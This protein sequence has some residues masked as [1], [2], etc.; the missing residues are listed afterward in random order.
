MPYPLSKRSRISRVQALRPAG[1]PAREL[2][3][4]LTDRRTALRVLLCALSI[5]A[6]AASL[7]AWKF[8]FPYRLGQ[9]PEHGVAARLDFERIN[10]VATERAR[11]LKAAQV[12]Y[13]FRQDPAPLQKLPSQFKASLHQLLDAKSVDALPVETRAALGLVAIK[14]AADKPPAVQPAERF[15]QLK[16]AVGD[17]PQ[18]NAIE[19]ELRAFLEPIDR[20]GVMPSQP[21]PTI[22][23]RPDDTLQ[24][25]SGSHQELMMMS[26]LQLPQLLSPAG[27]LGEAW[28]RFPTLSK[29]RPTVEHW[30]AAKVPE[31]LRYDAE[32]TQA[33]RERARRSVGVVKEVYKKGNLLVLPG[34]RIDAEHLALLTAEYNASDPADFWPLRVLTSVALILVLT[35]L[36]GYYVVRQEPKL[37]GSAKRLSIYLT[38]VVLTAALARSLSFDPWRAEVIPLTALVMILAIAYNQVLATL[39]GFSLSLI[40]TLATGADL[41]HFVVL[42]SAAAA[43]VIPL[44]RVSSR[45]TLIHVGLWSGLTY[46]FVSWGTAAIESSSFGAL[47]RDQ[48]VL[49]EALRGAGWCL[50]SGFLVAGSL[51]FIE[52]A[53]GVVTNISLLEMGDISHPLLQEL[54]RRA[55]GT[56]NHSITVAT[57]AETAAE[58]IGAN[59]LLVR[60]GAYFHDIGKML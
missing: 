23:I 49:F 35:I 54:V 42:M 20:T 43:A 29:I 2:L 50:V 16:Q 38:A 10:P 31:T 6:M 55:P 59:G 36:N 30:L 46:F 12:P 28:V 25:I 44:S 52:S 47:V 19:Q 48:A 60:V 32:A 40:I 57:I 9:R 51:P 37:A 17:E 21:D 7:E 26:Q 39:T 41:P 45:S 18:L 8:P 13:I 4:R 34:A 14:P 24:I 1:S 5:A 27:L 53:F 33:A 58:Q 15:A 3:S 11:E 56:Y 22:D